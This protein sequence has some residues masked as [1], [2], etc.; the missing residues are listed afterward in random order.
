MLQRGEVGP[1]IKV[2]VFI[3]REKNSVKTTWGVVL[4]Q[5]WQMYTV[6]AVLWYSLTTS[7]GSPGHLLPW[8]LVVVAG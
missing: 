6:A 1:R 8:A 7:A 4:S 2:Y 5:H 3:Q